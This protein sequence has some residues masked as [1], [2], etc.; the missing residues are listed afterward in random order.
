M[1]NYFKLK[2]MK[3]TFFRC[4]KLVIINRNMLH[5][6]KKLVIDNNYQNILIRIF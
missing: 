6:M 5:T 1:L 4:V 2:F 3:N